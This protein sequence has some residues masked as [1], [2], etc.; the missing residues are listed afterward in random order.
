[1]PSLDALLELLVERFEAVFKI[2]LGRV[3]DLLRQGPAANP[4]G[5]RKLLERLPLSP[6]QW[7][8]PISAVWPG[9]SGFGSAV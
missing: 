9:R 1:M 2:G 3:D 5:I 7:N 8:S 4:A 6:T